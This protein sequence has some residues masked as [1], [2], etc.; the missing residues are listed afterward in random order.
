LAVVVDRYSASASEIF[1]GAIQDYS[2]GIVIG[3]QTFGK[4]TVQSLYPLDR[5]SRFQS[6]KGFGQLTLTIGKFYRV[7]G[8]GTQN[9]GVVPDIELPSLI[10][11]EVIGEIT[12][13]NKLPWDQIMSLEYDSDSIFQKSIE[14]LKKNYVEK[15]K[16]NLPLLFLQEDID[17]ITEQNR[18]TKLSLNYEKRKVKRDQLKK[19]VQDRRTK[20]MEE[21][22]FSDK[23]NFDEFASKT[24]LNEVLNTVV[25]LIESK[26]IEPG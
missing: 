16:E 7:S 17:Q 18:Q 13:K 21:L 24:L 10:D 6:K 20:R 1:A 3:Q 9:K 2:R 23:D 12:K 22:G 8:Q 14:K 25:D 5:Y 11:Q 4:G 19:V 26:E 15:S